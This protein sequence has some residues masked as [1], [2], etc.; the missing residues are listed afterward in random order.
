MSRRSTLAAPALEFEERRRRI[1][2]EPLPANI[3]ELL[4]TAARDAGN[5]LLWD[6]FE[7]GERASY[8]E[9]YERV[10]RLAAGLRSIGVRKGTHVAVMLPNVEAFPLTWLAIGV[11]GAVMVP[12]NVSYQLRELVYVLEDSDAEYLVADAS[13]LDT[14]TAG[15][16]SG[17]IRLPARQIVVR[18]ASGLEGDWAWETLAG[19]GDAFSPPEVGLDD[20]LN[21]QYTS[22]TT[23]FPKGCM[24]AQRYWIVCGKVNAARDARRFERIL[25]STPFYYMDPQ[26]LLLMTIYQRATLFVAARQSAS[27]FTSWLQRFQIQFCLF[28]YV[29]FKQPPSPDDRVPCVIR[30]NVYGVPKSIHAALEERFDFCAREAFGMTEVGSAMFMPIEA[31]DMAGSGSC[32]KPSPFRECRIVDDAGNPVAAGEIG[33]L[34]IRGPG[35]LMGY[36]NNPEATAAA[37]RDGWFRTGDLFRQDERGYFYI[38]GRAKDMI[39]RSSENIAAREVEAVLNSVPSV[40]ESAAIGV[41]DELRGEEVKAYLVLREGVQP[42][43]SVIQEAIA[44]C[45]AQLARFKVPRYYSFRTALPKTPSLKIAKQVLKT[46]AGNAAEPTFDR[47]EQRWLGAPL[48][49]E[50]A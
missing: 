27:R 10:M 15:M 5:Q 3:H 23:G 44:T 37:I 38:V 19:C 49:E 6:F 35:I 21:I 25:A 33:E 22:G 47:V 46:E 50:Q 7:S 45:T 24:L 48:L 20:L 28:P 40:L 18:G 1:E 14:V 39:R 11:L 2:A 41:P 16:A 13:R 26:W 36:Y 31:A 32:G 12:V 34:Q 17:D 8:R 29:V 9:V 4:A 43:T 42:S 30:G